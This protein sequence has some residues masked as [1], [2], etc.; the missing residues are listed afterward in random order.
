LGSPLSSI[1]YIDESGDLG[2][3]FAS[4]YRQGGSSRYLT[5]AALGVPSHK[6][7]IPKRVIKNLYTHFKWPIDAEKK[8]KSMGPAERTA[9]ASA[10]LRMCKDHPDIPLHAISL[11]KERVE[12]HIRGDESKLYNYMIRLCVLDC[13][14][15]QDELTLVPDPRSIKV[16]SGR[17]LHDYLQIELW[18]S[19][20]AK[21]KLTTSPLGSKSSKGVQFAD[22]RCGSPSLRQEVFCYFHQRMVR[23]V[24]TRPNRASI[25]SP[26]SRTR[27]PSRPR[28]WRSSTSS[29]ATRSISLAPASSCARSPSPGTRVRFVF[30]CGESDMVNQVPEYPAAPPVDGPFAI[31]TVQAAALTTINTPQEEESEADRLHSAVQAQAENELAEELRRKPTARVTR[32]PRFR[33]ASR[34][35]SRMIRGSCR[36]KEAEKW[37][38]RCR[39]QASPFTNLSS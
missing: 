19:R 1:I 12:Q 31:A 9:F 6:K 27:S 36:S 5:I 28:S 24:R 14:E 33:Y 16:E 35:P 29:S 20:R 26:I 25:P 18:F 21:T 4:P 15:K 32:A 39:L 23:G 30:D 13:M 34:S 8:W 2:W 11:K 3:S 10:A 22:I 37:E 7:H 38:Q 17:S